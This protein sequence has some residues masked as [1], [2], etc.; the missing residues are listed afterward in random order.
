MTSG[1]KTGKSAVH[2]RY[3]GSSVRGPLHRR[4]KRPCEDAWRAWS[5]DDGAAIAV[6]DGMGSRPNSRHGARVATRA[7]I[8][9]FRQWSRQPAVST[10]WLAR[11]CEVHWRFGIA[12]YAP[13]DCASTCLL[14]GWS[15]A[16]GLLLAG[17]GDGMILLRQ[18]DGT[19]SRWLDRQEGQQANETIALGFPHKIGDWVLQRADVKAPWVAV[20]MSDGVADDL[21]NERLSDFVTW[22][23][24]KATEPEPRQRRALLRQAL[25]DWP[26]PGHTDDK[27]VAVLF[28][29]A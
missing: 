19:L 26:T 3:F 5:G 29:H 8:A 7:S 28:A 25:N 13:E 17:L 16:A 2:V 6:A 27:T 21:N 15:P 22:L 10:D 1:I 23:V 20:L 4:E 14:A 24:D 18:A 12:P 11:A 9:A